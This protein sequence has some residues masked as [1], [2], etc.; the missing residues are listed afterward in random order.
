MAQHS[1][2][3]WYK[4]LLRP[5]WPRVACAIV[6]LLIGSGGWLAMGQAIRYG[7]DSGFISENQQAMTYAGIGLI[8]VTLM[9]SFATYWRFYLM[10]WLGER[11]SADIRMQVYQ[12]MLTLGPSFYAKTRTGEVIS[13][14]TSDTSVLQ[15]VI[16]SSLSMAVRSAVTFFGSLILMLTASSTLTVAVLISVPIILLPL[17]FLAPKLRALARAS[18]DRVADLGSHID[19]SLHEIATVQAYNAEK[20]EEAFFKDRVYDA[21]GT[22]IKRTKIRAWLIAV[23]MGLSMASIIVIGWIGMMQVQNGTLSVGELTAFLFYAV[24]AG[25]SIATISEVVGDIQRGAGASERLYDLLRSQNPIVEGNTSQSPVTTEAPSITFEGMNFHYKEDDPIFAGFSLNIAP[26]EQVAL[27][28]P[29][30]A[31]KSTLFNLL[32]RFWQPQQGQITVNGID[33]STLTH[34]ALRQSIAV[35]DQSAVVFADTVLNNIRYS[36]PEATLEEV[37]EAAKQAYADEFI[38]KLADGYD[39]ELGERGVNLSGGQRQRIAIARAILADRPILL[40]DEATSALDAESESIIQA[41]LKRLMASRTTLVIAHRLATV[42]DV[43]RIVV[44]DDGKIQ[45]SGRHEELLKTSELYQ[46]YTSLQLLH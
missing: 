8:I 44:L 31:G 18:Q 40:L 20:R 12:Q 45:A 9:I 30:G 15:T 33:I 29:S 46:R 6:A 41:A 14:F 19:Q 27:V 13:R 16:G 3:S 2:S 5:Y 37:K 7:I 28:G 22:A 24:M 4:Q 43:D 23:V 21:L 32:L 38:D 11:V 34:E 26:G 39:T 17:R 1:L 42:K 36:K 35:V 10:T 25:G